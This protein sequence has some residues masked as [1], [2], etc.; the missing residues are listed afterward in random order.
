MNKLISP[1]K[2]RMSHVVLVIIS[3]AV[4]SVFIRTWLAVRK[5][6]AKKVDKREVGSFLM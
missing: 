2:Y 1:T 5:N 6:M 3:R 4:P